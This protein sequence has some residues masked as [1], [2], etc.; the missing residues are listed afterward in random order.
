MQHLQRDHAR[1]EV[2][3]RI[4]A[5]LRHRDAEPVIE[6][7]NISRK[8]AALMA[9]SPIGSVPERAEL[10]MRTADAGEWICCPCELRY[11]LGENRPDGEPA[12]LHGVR[13]TDLTQGVSEFI[14]RLIARTTATA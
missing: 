13:F 6:V 11:I 14:D 2:E 1:V 5:V 10:C 9:E 7:V 4:R 3:G 12:W 8:G